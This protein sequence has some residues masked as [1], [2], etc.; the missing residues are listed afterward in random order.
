[1]FKFFTTPYGDWNYHLIPYKKWKRGYNKVYK[2]L[3]IDPGVNDLTGK[4]DYP[5]IADYPL[6]TSGNIYWVIPDYPSDVS[7][8]LN[9]HECLIKSW[10]N[11]INWSYLPNTITSV[12]Y[13]YENIES[14]K[15]NYDNLYPLAKIIGIGN[16]CHSKK[17]IFL[18]K[19][20]DYVLQN[21]PKNKWIHFFGLYKPAIKYLLQFK[22]NFEVS[23][24][25][26]KWDYGMHQEDRK[27]GT[28]GN[29]KAGRWEKFYKYL[30]DLGCSMKQDSLGRYL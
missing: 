16:L 12:Q 23:V 15:E 13:Y 8:D 19:V 26:M 24:D 6:E 9:N 21:N 5:L 29:T 25:S 1:M 18:K 3:I 10:D 22:V 20:I 17:L 11:I 14:F 27:P 30:D 28:Y 4:K 2:N 7:P